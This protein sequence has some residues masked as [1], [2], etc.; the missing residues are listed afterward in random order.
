L[1][2]ILD[3]LRRADAER[4]RG[5]VPGLHTQQ[6]AATAEATPAPGAPPWRWLA[7]V[8]ATGVVAALVA[9]MI[10]SREP[11]RQAA[12]RPSPPAAA[13]ASPSAPSPAVPPAVP[14]SAAAAAP[15]APMPGAG[16]SQPVAEPAPWPAPAEASR[17]AP[18][19]GVA[20][21]SAAPPPAEAAVATR[22]QLPQEIRAQLPPL[23]VG[24]SIYSA[25]PPDRS[26]IIDG[27]LL[28][29]NDRLGADLTVEQI[30]PRS[31]VLRIKGHRFEIGF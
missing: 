26:V 28:R 13:A 25:N 16:Q 15:V 20:A 29:E 17:K 10:A 18:P 6:A 12:A 23:A 2:L 1:S 3:A 30:R 19:P 27:R 9:W 5:A 31:A 24:G 7:L 8:A 4:D 11:P 14:P 22:E 21:A